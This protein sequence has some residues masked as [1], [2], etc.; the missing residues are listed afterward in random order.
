[1]KLAPPDAATREAVLDP[2]RSFHLESPAGSGKTTLLAARYLL[3][4]GHCRPEEVLALTFTRKAAGELRERILAA[5]AQARTGAPADN[6]AQ[7]QLAAL[8]AAVV[9][10]HNLAAQPLAPERLQVM[11]F[12]GLCHWLVTRWPLEAGLN[13]GTGVVDEAQQPA[14]ARE[15]LARL[16][17]HLFALE[18]DAP[19]RQALERRLLRLDNRWDALEGELAAILAQRDLFAD[20]TAEVARGGP[21]L[22]QALGE[23]LGVLIELRLERAHQLLAESELG[24]R[25]AEVAAELARRGCAEALP[26]TLPEPRAANA[27]AFEALAR[28]LLT[29]NGT[30]RRQ[31]GP[32]CGYPNGFGNSSAAAL[33][34]GLP[35]DCCAALALC[36]GLPGPEA[37]AD[38]SALAD[39][40]L[41]AAHAERL[42][43]EVCRERGVLDFVGLEEAALRLLAQEPFPQEGLLALDA[44][45]RH[46][47]VDEFQDTSRHQWLLLARL[48]AG[49]APGDGRT[50]FLVGDPKQS[51]YGFRKAEVALFSEAKHGLPLEGAGRLPLEP[52]RLTANFRSARPLINWSNRLFERLMARPFREADE[53][54]FAAAEPTRQEE[55]CVSLSL[56]AAGREAEARWLAAAVRREAAALGPR[57]RLAVLLFAR[58]HLAAYVKAL[59]E[60]GVPVSV[61]EGLPLAECSE[62]AGLLAL[63]RAMV[64]PHDDLAWAVLLRSP[65]GLVEAGILCQVAARE[66]AGWQEKLAGHPDLRVAALHEAV[67]RGQEMAARLPLA[68]AVRQVL[69]DLHG[70]WEAACRLGRAALGNLAAALELLRGCEAGC[71]EETLAAFEERLE[72]AYQP[73][74]EG[75]AGPSVQMM[76]VHAAKGLEFDVVFLPHLDWK[77]VGH[78]ERPP[79]LLE[80]LPGGEHVAALPADRRANDDDPVWKLVS[81]FSEARRL[82]EAKRLFYTAATRAR[83]ALHLSG[84]APLNDHGRLRVRKNSP[85]AWLLSAEGLGAATASDLDGA[86]LGE[87]SVRLDPSAEAAPPSQA[88]PPREADRPRFRPEPLGYRKLSA[89][90]LGGETPE[91]RPPAIFEPSLEARVRG[92]L[93]HRLLEAAGRGEPPGPAQVAAALASEGLA[94][95][96]AHA[97]AAELTS[98]VALCLA[99]SFLQRALAAP[100]QYR[101]LALEALAEGPAGPGRELDVGI[102]DLLWREGE[103]WWV[104]DYKTS[105]P[106]PGVAE[107][108]FLA[109][110]AGKYAPQLAAYRRLVAAWQGASEERVRAALYFTALRRAVEV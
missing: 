17:R 16:R 14:L 20:L 57:E 28:A 46:V 40:V 35:A 8:A 5:L 59:R 70:P 95:D 65:W 76:T 18:P 34:K 56:F 4:L 7:A 68:C 96:R 61:R 27:P 110:E 38:V 106:A 58:T 53:V 29:K 15:A 37:G 10:R 26:P 19:P 77:P 87:M 63:A 90:E 42:H 30:P 83:R 109:E 41:L 108:D 47:L 1:M 2:A 101:E 103:T 69:I 39:L 99:D 105:Q 100:E 84:V 36:R 24:R 3:L 48:C 33:I 50:L 49:F 93:I 44:R 81:G 66:G 12:H 94:A 98:E 11:T 80:R 31:F 67:L 22:A 9:R 79:Y 45:L 85:L 43:G 71:P 55:G 54:E 88:A 62:V 97:L 102:I 75:P 32:S 51:I 23:R 52:L 91:E 72:G 78:H 21:A 60:L 107:A 64:R 25:W 104:V 13:P 74:Q 6:P 89:S 82:G 92:T 86:R 73:Q